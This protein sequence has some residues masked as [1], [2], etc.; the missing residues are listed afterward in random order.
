[1]NDPNL[2][3]AMAFPPPHDHTAKPPRSLKPPAQQPRVVLGSHRGG[4]SKIT[5]SHHPRSPSRA[6]AAAAANGAY[7]RFMSLLPS[8]NPRRQRRAQLVVEAEGLGTGGGHAR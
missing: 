6:P 1:L 5:D 2:D 4:A 3:P 7:S 8:P